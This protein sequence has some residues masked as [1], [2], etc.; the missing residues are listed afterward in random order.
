MKLAIAVIS[1]IAYV[2]ANSAFEQF[3]IQQRE[4]L[5]KRAE[6][7]PLPGQDILSDQPLDPN[8][9]DC[10]E[11]S[12][13]VEGQIS[14]DFND[15]ECQEFEDLEC[16]DVP[17]GETIDSNQF[18]CEEFIDEFADFDCEDTDLKIEDFDCEEEP[19]S[20][21]TPVD[22][23]GQPIAGGSGTTGG[24]VAGNETVTPVDP[25]A[26]ALGNG[27]D[28]A[29]PAAA[30]SSAFTVSLASVLAAGLLFVL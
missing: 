22:G 19:G 24:E 26:A 8:E 25:N 18:D 3:M 1:S 12:K 17:Q 23:T 29:A 6:A 13:G 15:V 21:A 9:F 2:S 28:T 10:E 16:E 14:F 7:S 27:T 11:I 30:Q 4:M 5:L 20:G